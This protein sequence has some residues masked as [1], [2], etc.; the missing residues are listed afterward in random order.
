MMRKFRVTFETEVEIHIDDK[1]IHQ[2]D[3]EWRKHFYADLTSPHKIAEHLAY[4]IV[5]YDR[6]L[7]SLDGFANLP[8]NSII[9]KE[10]DWDIEAIE[11]TK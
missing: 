11:E 8:D 10:P 9:S 7:S 2:V 4:N 5:L 6:K 1:V 3:A